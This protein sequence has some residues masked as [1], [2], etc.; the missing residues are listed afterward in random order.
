[1]TRKLNRAERRKYLKDN[2]KIEMI[3]IK[4]G[5]PSRFARK[6]RAVRSKKLT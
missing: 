3:M 4:N 5:K 1:M 6:L 2:R